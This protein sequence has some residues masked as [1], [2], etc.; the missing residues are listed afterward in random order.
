MVTVMLMKVMAMEI[1]PLSPKGAELEPGLSMSI[2]ED[3]PSTS[4]L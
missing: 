2:V 4:P 3:E 1:S